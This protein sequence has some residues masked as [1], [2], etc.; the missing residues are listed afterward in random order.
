MPTEFPFFSRAAFDQL[1]ADFY[2]SRKPGSRRKAII[3]REDYDLIIKILKDPEDTS[4]GTAK[5][6][7]W[8]KNSFYL[9]DIGTSQNPILQVMTCNEDRIVCPFENLYDVIGKIHGNIQKHAGS[10]TT[11]GMV[12][13]RR[14]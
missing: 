12:S 6:R 5:D 3:T 10:K 8:T 11:Y 7:F 2:E 14:L 9:R 1:I 4:N 13:F